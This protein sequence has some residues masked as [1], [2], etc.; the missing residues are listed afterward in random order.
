MKN[1][2][3]IKPEISP[4]NE[5]VELLL[6]AQDVKSF[7]MERIV[8]KGH[9][10]KDDFWYNQEED[11]W[12]LLVQGNAILKMENEMSTISLKKGDYYFIPKFQKHRVEYT[13]SIPE[14]IWLAIFIK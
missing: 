4:E 3:E 13:S 10:S 2:F 8:S 5:L 9:T 11:E 6:E 7:R 14:C 12:V 1:I